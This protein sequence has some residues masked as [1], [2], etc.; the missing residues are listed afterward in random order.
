MLREEM[1]RIVTQHI[2]DRESV[3][4]DQVSLSACLSVCVSVW[5]SCLSLRHICHVIHS[6]TANRLSYQTEQ[7]RFR[8]SV[9]QRDVQTGACLPLGFF[10]DIFGGF[11][12]VFISWIGQLKSGQETGESKRE[13][14]AAKGH[15]WNRTRGCCSKD[16]TLYMWPCSSNWATGRLFL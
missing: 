3:T 13:W 6:F 9:L 10:K 7:W 11:Y 4:K 2:R 8:C 14:H 16:K 5:P 1:E 12:C 15:R